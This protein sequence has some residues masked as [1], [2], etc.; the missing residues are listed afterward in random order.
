ML[1]GLPVWTSGRGIL[2]R[3]AYFLLSEVGDGRRASFLGVVAMKNSSGLSA[4]KG[5][6]LDPNGGGE[7]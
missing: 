2:V 6:G 1:D 7:G 5:M 4:G 3:P